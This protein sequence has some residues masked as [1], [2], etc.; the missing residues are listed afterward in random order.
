MSNVDP[1]VSAALTP[2]PMRMRA[3]W[4]SYCTRPLAWVALLVSLATVAIVG[5][6]IV[7]DAR[8]PFEHWETLQTSDR[9]R[10]ELL[11]ERMQWDS[12]HRW[13]VTPPIPASNP[14][15]YFASPEL[16][17]IWSRNRPV[18]PQAV[19]TVEIWSEKDIPDDFW[20]PGRYPR[21]ETVI[22]Y[23]EPLSTET[24][25]KLLQ[26]YRL[27]AI[28]LQRTE[29]WSAE[30]LRLL[31]SADHL[32]FLSLGH[33]RAL[34]EPAALP[35]P[36]HLRH[37]SLSIYGAIPLARVQEWRALAR[38][39]SLDLSVAAAQQSTLLTPE[40]VT[41]LDGFPQRPTL[42]L[43]V[44]QGSD[45]AWAVEAQSHFQR[46][47]VR[48][49][50]I[51]KVRFTGA[52]LAF[53]LLLIPTAF[54]LYQL[55][56]QSLL[57]LMLLAP[58]AV[59][60]HQNWAARLWTVGGVISA[61]FALYSGLHW[62]AALAVSVSG[63]LWYQGQ[64]WILQRGRS[65]EQ[66]GFAHPIIAALP[67]MFIGMFGVVGTAMVSYFPA[68]A[69]EIDWFLR[70]QRPVW[71]MLVFVGGVVSGRN[72]LWRAATIH[73]AA[74]EA[75]L[76]QVPMS[77]LDIGGWNRACAPL[78]G[79]KLDKMI[80]WNPVM[81]NREQRIEAALSRGPALTRRQR[82]SVW[83]CGLHAHPVDIM[84]V[85][86][87][88]GLMQFAIFRY[89]GQFGMEAK[90]E[91]VTLIVPALQVLLMFLMYPIAL[92]AVRRRWMAQELLFPLTRQDW[93][94]DW[95]AVQACLLLPV[96]VAVM[97]LVILDAL[98][99]GIVRPTTTEVLWGAAGILGAMIAAWATSLIVATEYRSPTW[100]T[101]V[102]GLVLTAIAV[103]AIVTINYFVP[104]LPDVIERFA[105]SPAAPYAVS[106]VVVAM[107]AGLVVW[108]R[109]R[110][111]AWEVGRLH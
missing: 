56:T 102:W 110:W 94:R 4:L 29:K 51:P 76:G 75:G 98:L 73:R 38:L 33:V 86:V 83:M 26:T 97:L 109:R 6:M 22:A 88:I 23:V 70:G 52:Y 104:G 64:S 82:I 59:A 8:P 55:S 49:R 17:T 42:Y 44:L 34:T 58:G 11:V 5:V 1:V 2:L 95:Y 107:V 60:P 13:S 106:S 48:P 63:V 46:L 96:P 35:W 100:A 9:A 21:V 12:R 27:K 90:V 69:G 36:K 40:F 68:L 87:I 77:S 61:G 93:K 66:V 71:A 14:R 15:M 89:L 50:F 19:R 92:L 74:Q 7:S 30:E 24:L 105:E 53:V 18:E 54:G 57:P 78:T 37:L 32:E 67:L 85:I 103:A 43:D 3:V 41:E 47:A 108:A 99:G 10:N 39:M 20:E 84:T 62:S 28:S 79:N 45:G 72:L 91:R 65:V 80:R 31:A 81:R 25:R 16:R 111:D 101:L